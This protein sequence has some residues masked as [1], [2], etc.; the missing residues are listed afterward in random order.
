MSSLVSF[1]TKSTSKSTSATSSNVRYG[2]VGESISLD[3][4][5][6]NQNFF[7]SEIHSK[8]SNVKFG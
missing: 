4:N 5:H 3:A 7:E 6:R 1:A 2:L 8:I